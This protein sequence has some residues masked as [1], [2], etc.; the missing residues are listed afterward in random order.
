MVELLAM[1]HWREEE[2]VP[3]RLHYPSELAPAP[4]GDEYTIH[5]R[6]PQTEVQAI[7]TAL[8]AACN[9]TA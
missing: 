6:L 8:I 7:V 4:Q 3:I 5:V 2:A 1:T 9:Q